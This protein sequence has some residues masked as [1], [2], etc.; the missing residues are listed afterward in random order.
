M[1]AG[2]GNVG[3]MTASDS[4]WAEPLSCAEGAAECEAGTN[5]VEEATVDLSGPG[6]AAAGNGEADEDSGSAGDAAG[7]NDDDLDRTDDPMTLYL[8]DVG[9]TPLLTREGETALAKRIEAGRRTMLDGLCRSLPAIATVCMWRDA[10]REGTLALRHVVD[11]AATY[12]GMRQ[13]DNG[14]EEADGAGDAHG[15]GEDLEAA[16]PRLAAM[17]EAALPAV[18]EILDRT[19]T[20]HA[21]LR[22]L[23]EKRIELARRNRTPTSLQETRRRALERAVA[24]SMGSL[25]LTDARIEVLVNEVR[26][27]DKRLRRCEGALL[28][29][30][31]GCGVPH[32]AFLEQY[33]GREL[34]SRWLSRVGRRR[35]E[36]WKT[37]AAKKRP[38]V[39]ALRRDILE[40]ARESATMP[41]D[42]RRT[43]AM[44][45]GGERQV[46]QA[47]DEMIEANLRLVVSIAKKYQ[48]R[49]LALPDLVQEGNAGLMHAVDRFDYRRG[50]RFSTYATWWI[51]QSIARAVSETGPAIRIP[52]HMVETVNKVKRASWLM[53]RELGRAPVPEEVAERTGMPLDRVQKALAAAAAAEPMSLEMPLGGD[54][55]D[56]R[57]GDL[58]EDEDAVQPLDAAI[59]SDLRDTVSRLLGT[60]TPREE[61]VLRMRFGIGTKSDHTLGEVGLQLSVTRERI[62]QIEARAL[63]KLKHPARA[64]VL[65]SFLEGQARPGG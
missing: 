41:E 16:A 20:A 23:H 42:L 8:R 12:G 26:A 61:R 33:R 37:L 46:R 55:G 58:I 43:A 28:R 6:I 1:A 11:V 15:G 14:R 56:L 24:A 19:A 21:K 17:E 47:T 13:A 27:A 53:A 36:G 29:L 5:R 30:A 25:R 65:R 51:R 38:E 31:T 48:H 44:V 52:V 59:G 62:R 10:I 4:F 63:R 49:G 7:V 35:G 54:D 34:E 40:L 45:L 64:R 2:H 18:M 22:R 60:L 39:L 3:A 32:E 50:F 57:L 9:G